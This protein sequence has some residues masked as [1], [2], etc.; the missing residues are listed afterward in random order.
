MQTK[1]DKAGIKRDNKAG[2]GRKDDRVGNS[3]RDDKGAV[4][5]A[6]GFHPRR[7]NDGVGDPG[8]DDEGAAEPAAGTCIGVRRLSRHAFLLAASSNTFLAFSSLESLIG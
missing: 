8:Q 2:T 5:S 1:D 3:G 4:E 6:V 7:D